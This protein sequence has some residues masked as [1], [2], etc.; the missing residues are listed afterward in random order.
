[1]LKKTYFFKSKRHTSPQTYRT[2]LFGN[3]ENNLSSS[4]DVTHAL[5][6]NSRLKKT[7]FKSKRH[8]STQTHQTSLFENWENNRSTSPDATYALTINSRLNF[9]QA[10]FL[11]LNRSWTRRAEWKTETTHGKWYN[12]H[13]P[14]DGMGML[15]GASPG[16]D[17]GGQ[18]QFYT[19][20]THIS[21]SNPGTALA[22]R[23][24]RIPADDWWTVLA[25]YFLRRV[26]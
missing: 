4:A 12:V 10:G 21:V 20:F 7:L 19:H 5:T 13:F 9:R 26:T 6:I 18:L 24:P 11:I 25:S 3:W 22:E 8:I 16:I 1:M 23:E 15:K 14:L 17:K 2:S